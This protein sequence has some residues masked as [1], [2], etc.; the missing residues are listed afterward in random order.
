MA[1]KEDVRDE[2]Q[3]GMGRRLMDAVESSVLG[4]YLVGAKTKKKQMSLLETLPLGGRRQLLLV[5]CGTDIF[6]VG[7]GADSVGTLVRVE[8]LSDASAGVATR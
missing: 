8:S 2:R 3:R 7:A 5:Q 6:V 4:P 1:L